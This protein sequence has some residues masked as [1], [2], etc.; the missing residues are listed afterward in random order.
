VTAQAVL[1]LERRP[2]PVLPAAARGHSR[3]RPA[4]PFAEVLAAVRALIAAV[5]TAVTIH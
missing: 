4:D 2:L 5:L 3:A 1:A